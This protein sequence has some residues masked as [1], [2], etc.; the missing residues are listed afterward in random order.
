MSEEKGDPFYLKRP[1]WGRIY[2][3]YFPTHTDPMSRAAKVL[4]EM[5]RRNGDLRKLEDDYGYDRGQ[6][7]SWIEFAVIELWKARAEIKRLKARLEKA[8]P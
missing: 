4:S 8:P 6:W 1:R 7:A 2:A 5:I 3:R